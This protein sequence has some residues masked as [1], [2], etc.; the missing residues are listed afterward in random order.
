M[1]VMMSQSR[2]H[3]GSGVRMRKLY[4]LLCVVLTLPG[5]RGFLPNFWSRVLTLSL[6][7]YTHQFIT[8]QGVLNVTL[9]TLS[10][11]NTHQHRHTQ[12][13]AGL[14]RGFWHA[15]GEV[16]RSNAAMDFLSST[17]SDP[18]YHFD[19]ERV[20]ESIA[21]LRQFWAQTLLSARAKEYQGARHS[22]GQLLHSLQDF[23]SHSN[24]VEM[25]Q[26]SIYLHLLQPGQPAFPVATE[27][28]PTCMECH[29]VTCR[30]NLL[31]RLTQSQQ[32]PLLLTTGYFRT[33]PPKPHGKCS[34]GGILDSSRHQGAKGGIN[35]DST[36]PLF[37]PHHYLHV[38]AARL[39]TMA[40]L[41][42]LRDLRDSVGNTSFLRWGLCSLHY[43]VK[44]TFLN[45]V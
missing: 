15:V 30:D 11:D 3:G 1:E 18:V 8:E 12:E 28:T 14:G 13:Q 27:D 9:E 25:G 38:E 39:A 35:K 42:V 31:P 40:T 20:E 36:S 16:V 19:S 5:C 34:H 6:D 4:V 17:R 7:S 22:L 45:K 2:G 29:S 33:Y 32:D 10:M 37:S 23:Y 26:H 21:M 43:D 24:W 44:Y 41:T